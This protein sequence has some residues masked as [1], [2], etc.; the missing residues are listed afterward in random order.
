MGK[1]QVSSF[2]FQAG[3]EDAND[4][5][6]ETSNAKP[7]LQPRLLRLERSLGGTHAFDRRLAFEKL[8]VAAGLEFVEVRSFEG[9][10]AQKPYAPRSPETWN[11]KL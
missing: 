1:V 8:V 7:F 3:A 9:R 10:R 11:L 2:R 4:L 6:L 5:E